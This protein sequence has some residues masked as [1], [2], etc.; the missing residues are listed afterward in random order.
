MAEEAKTDFGAY[1]A[2]AVLTDPVLYNI[3]RE[4]R[5]EFLAE[6]LRMM[7]LRRWRSLDQL[8]GKPRHFEGFKIWGPMQEQYEGLRYGGDG[9]PNVSPPASAGGSDY[10]LPTA[11]NPGSEIYKQGGHVWKMGHYLYPGAIEHFSITAADGQTA[12][13]SPIYQNPYWPTNPSEPAVQ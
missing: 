6:G 8:V 11:I 10:L 7:D 4:R 2:G 12:A 13:D 9:T 3:R 5:M 1:S